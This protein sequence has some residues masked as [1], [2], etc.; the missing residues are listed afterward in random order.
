MA[1]E[2][3]QSWPSEVMRAIKRNK[4]SYQGWLPYRTPKTAARYQQANQ[5]AALVVAKAKSQ[6][7]EKFGHRARLSV[8][9]EA[10]LSNHHTTR[11]AEAMLCPHSVNSASGILLLTVEPILLHTERS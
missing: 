3:T 9:L 4:G 5:S 7:W 8:G 11:E 1:Q 6:V 10:I 2:A